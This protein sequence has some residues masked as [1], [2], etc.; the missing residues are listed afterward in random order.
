MDELF[1]PTN[2]QTSPNKINI[3]TFKT[4]SNKNIGIITTCSP[5]ILSKSKFSKFL[6]FKNSINAADLEQ[7][8]LTFQTIT[9]KYQIATSHTI[10]YEYAT[11]VI[12]QERDPKFFDKFLNFIG[13]EDVEEKI[14]RKIVQE[15]IDDEIRNSDFLSMEKFIFENSKIWWFFGSI[16]LTKIYKFILLNS[17]MF[18]VGNYLLRELNFTNFTSLQDLHFHQTVKSI[19][20]QLLILLKFLQKPDRVETKQ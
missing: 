17:F 13:V 18:I 5:K 7:N 19:S 6:N 12:N 2:I 9:K 15:K 20:E 11:D 4:Q 16:D 14:S 1:I 8:Q 10:I 3:Y